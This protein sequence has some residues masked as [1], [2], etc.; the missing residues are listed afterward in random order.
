M[1]QLLKARNGEVGGIPVARCL[2]TVGRR[3]IGAW[4]FLDHI[5]PVTFGEAETGL[6]VAPHPHIGL[7][8]FTWM[9]EGELLHR[10]SLGT[11]QPIRPGQVNLM[12]AGHGVSHTE[13][14]LFGERA[15]HAAQLWIA[16]PEADRNIPA[17]FDH[18]DSLP[19]WQAQGASWTLLT[20]QY[21]SRCAD[22]L[23]YSPLIGLDIDCELA[24][25]IDLILEPGFEYGIVP[26]TGACT[27]NDERFNTDELAYIE[28]NLDQL[29]VTCE[30][31]TRLLLIGGLPL[32]KE[33]VM[34]WNYVG[35]ERAEIVEAET[36][37]ENQSPRFGEIPDWPGE[38]TEGPPSPWRR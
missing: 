1:A 19:S 8:T 33:V 34:W 24:Q 28:G 38:R 7:Q 4:C 9:I 16:L 11:T 17:R 13:E 2:P 12:T 36:D 30:P 29:R 25:E 23:Q 21:G 6:R 10:D 26:L 35:Y 32:R 27:I 31:L 20:G 5:G 37:W 3:Q 22:T 15:L 18:Y 14:S